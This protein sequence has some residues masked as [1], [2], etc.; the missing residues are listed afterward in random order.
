MFSLVDHE[1]EDRSIGIFKGQPQEI[2]L[3]LGNPVVEFVAEGIGSAEEPFQGVEMSPTGP[4][5]GMGPIWL[6]QGVGEPAVD[7]GLKVREVVWRV[8]DPHRMPE[9][10]APPGRARSWVMLEISTDPCI[11]VMQRVTGI[12]GQSATCHVYNL[13]VLSVRIKRRFLPA[14]NDGASAPETNR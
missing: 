7:E 11:T 10:E 4:L 14:V 5:R 13:R 2:G 8:R 6:F 1:L 12:E 3:G 9:M